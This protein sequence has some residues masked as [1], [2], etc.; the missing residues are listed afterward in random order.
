MTS[1]ATLLV[2]CSG[3]IHACWNLFTKRSLNKQV[4]LWSIHVLAVAALF[5]FVA[6]ELFTNALQTPVVYYVLL[7][8]FSQL[9]YVYLMS[10]AYQFGDLS[11]VYPIIRGTSA[12]FVPIVGILLFGESLSLFG[13]VGLACVTG[14]LLIISGLGTSKMD[15]LSY[16]AILFAFLVGLSTIGYVLGDKVTLQY[17]SPLTVLE[18]SNL[19]FVVA[20]AWVSLK[21]K[22]ELRR[23]WQVNKKTIILGAIMSPTS[24]LLFLLAM[25]MAP[26]AHIAPVR[27]IGTV[28]GTLFGIYILKEQQGLKRV[29]MSAVIT[30][31]IICIGMWG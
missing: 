14:G 5:P 29:M 27:E 21:S 17:L 18:I 15:A 1:I 23:E 31:G 10:K 24:Y 22:E 12:F 11:Q 9:A 3:V 26:L 20:F 8:F 28:F 7:S 30:V 19:G 25:K 4:F 2:I 6:V 16:K 13:W